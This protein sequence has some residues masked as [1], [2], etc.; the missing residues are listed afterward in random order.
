MFRLTTFDPSEIT[1]EIIRTVVEEQFLVIQNRLESIKYDLEY[2]FRG[3]T[4]KYKDLNQ[5]NRLTLHKISKNKF[6]ASNSYINFEVEIREI[7]DTNIIE[8]FTRDLHYMHSSRDSGHAFG[9]FFKGDKIP[10]AIETTEPSSNIKD[11]K[12]EALLAHGIDPTKGVEIT[13]LY[14][15]PGSPKNSISVLDGFMS[16]YFQDKGMLAIFTT[17]M[18]M[19]AKTKGSAVSGGMNNVLLIKDLRHFFVKEKIKDEVVY[20]H[21]VKKLEEIDADIISTHLNSQNFMLLKF[22]NCWENNL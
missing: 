21:V 11:Y 17:T 2:I 10:F 22:I 12:R 19:Y 14:C 4:G 5:D 18:P 15:L 3:L 16:K 20:K 7:D 9:L 6:V 1:E 13:R 8:L